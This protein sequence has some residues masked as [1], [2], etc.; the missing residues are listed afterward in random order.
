MEG[1]YL[2]L[3]QVFGNSARFTFRSFQGLNHLFHKTDTG[4]FHTTEEYNK[5]GFVDYEVIETLA[6]WVNNQ[7]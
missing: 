3:M 2:P 4:V 6:N 7:D 1:D 5:E